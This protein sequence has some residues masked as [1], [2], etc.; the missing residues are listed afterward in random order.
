MP[1]RP[2]PLARTEKVLPGL[3]A[4]YILFGASNKG[5]EG[6]VAQMAWKMFGFCL[7]RSANDEM[8]VDDDRI[9]SSWTWT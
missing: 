5:S 7:S 3:L 4:R 2:K 8:D 9:P 6:N 1:V